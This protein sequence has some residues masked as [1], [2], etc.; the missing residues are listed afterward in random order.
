MVH[1]NQDQ[2]RALASEL[3]EQLG[4]TSGMFQSAAPHLQ[5]TCKTLRQQRDRLVDEICLLSQSH[6]A[7]G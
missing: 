7:K 2:S 3:K 4:L 6:K 5:T 1:K